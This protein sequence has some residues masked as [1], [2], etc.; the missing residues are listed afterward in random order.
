MRTLVA[1]SVFAFIVLLVPS[2]A[3]CQ[4]RKGAFQFSPSFGILW[5]DAT[6]QGFDLDARS[7][8]IGLD[9]S[10]NITGRIAIDGSFHWSQTRTQNLLAP[11]ESNIVLAGV[12]GTFHLTKSRVVPYAMGRFGY[13]HCG[14]EIMEEKPGKI[15]FSYGGGFKFLFAE[16]GGFSLDFRDIM[17]NIPSGN[18]SETTLHNPA[19]T[20]S[21]IFQFGG[22]PVKDTDSDGISDSRDKCSETPVGTVVDDKGCPLDS[23]SDGVFDGLDKCPDTPKH[24][25]VTE[26]GCPLDSDG[27]GIHDWSDKCPDTP[28]GARVDAD[29]CPKDTDGDGIYDGLDRC[30]ETLHGS[31]VDKEGCRISEE[32]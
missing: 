21:V 14:S 5:T 18:S 13:I 9:V 32:E 16:E 25:Q 2:A 12:G 23:D 7:A 31:R 27:D 10:R 26:K 17:F 28:E 15:F 4:I 1:A 22:R 29:G 6:Q 11:R 19:L 24:M 8:L 30:P 20:A 3:E